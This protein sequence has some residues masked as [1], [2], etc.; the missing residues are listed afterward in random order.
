[1]G[2]SSEVTGSPA[3]PETAEARNRALGLLAD[4]STRIIY[5]QESGE[6]RKTGEA[7]GLSETEIAQLPTLERGEGL[8]RLGERAFMVRHLCTPC[9]VA[10][11]DT[12][13]RM[14]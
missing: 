14:R 7:I 5:A 11:F 2:E 8:W 9:E 3:E 4:C 10:L 13:A 1:M 6:A 12:N